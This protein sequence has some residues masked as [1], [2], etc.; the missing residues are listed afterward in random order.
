MK[1]TELHIIEAKTIGEAY[2]KAVSIVLK[3]MAAEEAPERCEIC[4]KKVEN[5]S[6]ELRPWGEDNKWI[7]VECG[8]KDP[9]RVHERMMAMFANILLDV[10]DKCSVAKI[11]KKDFEVSPNLDFSK[12]PKV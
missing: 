2:E 12:C 10:L 1:H 3:K 8:Q 9:D 4:N 11:S 7:C 6:E 5:R